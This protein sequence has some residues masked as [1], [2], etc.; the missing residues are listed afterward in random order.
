[1]N[2]LP[3]HHSSALHMSSPL[4]LQ[5]LACIFIGSNLLPTETLHF[6]ILMFHSFQQSGCWDDVRILSCFI[7]SF[8]FL[9]GF[10]PASCDFSVFYQCWSVSSMQVSK[11]LFSHL[12]LGSW[13][14][15]LLLLCVEASG[16][17]PLF[18]EMF[19]A[20]HLFLNPKDHSPNGLSSATDL[21]RLKRYMF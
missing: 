21:F 5:P 15:F 4:L 6:A 18:H 11:T 19:L 2:K 8:W 7:L 10:S 17:N 12:Q 1:M 9:L 16:K 20:T 13:A 14:P 3:T